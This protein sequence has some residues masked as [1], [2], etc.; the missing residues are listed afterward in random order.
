MEKQ[1]SPTRSVERALEILECFLDK[2]EMILLEIAEKTGL[3]SST[4]LRILTALQEHDFVVKNPQNKR[5]HLGTKLTWLAEMVPSKSYEELKRTAS[6]HMRALNKKFNEDVRLFVP[7]GNSKLCVESVESTRELRQVVKVGTR[8]DLQRGAAGKIILSYMTPSERKKV[9]G[10]PNLDGSVYDEIRKCGLA[11]SNGEREAGLFG[12][13]VPIIDE[14]GEMI[15]AV[16]ISGPTDRFD[17]EGLEEKK[18]AILK[19]GEQI[20]YDWQHRPEVSNGLF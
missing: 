6:P 13:A 8:H 11:I 15:A 3:S 16:S 5:Y 2:E 7:D 20:S 17:N 4:A 14:K 12:I 1:N 10:N 18:S 19:M 9:T